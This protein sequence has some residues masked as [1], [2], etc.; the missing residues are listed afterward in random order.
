MLGEGLPRAA[1]APAGTAV[2]T[3]AEA[4]GAQAMRQGHHACAQPAPGQAIMR[5]LLVCRGQGMAYV[6]EDHL[7][8][9][10]R[11]GLGTRGDPPGGRCAPPPLCPAEPSHNSLPRWHWLDGL[12][13]QKFILAQSRRPEACGQLHWAKIKVA[14]TRLLPEAPGEGPSFLVQLRGSWLVPASPQSLPHP[15]VAPPLPPSPSCPWVWALP[16]SRTVL[17]PEPSLH[18][19]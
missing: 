14:R 16:K 19:I 10:R 7:A 5:S 2:P 4:A 8:S 9:K 12:R 1:R 18:D 17:T 15:H 11:S 13:L 6:S 3:W